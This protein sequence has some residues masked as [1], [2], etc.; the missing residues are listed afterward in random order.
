MPMV[1]FVTA[2]MRLLVDAFQVH[3][4]DYLLKPVEQERLEA[5]VNRCFERRGRASSRCG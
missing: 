5:A 3:A 4:V 1:V 2:S